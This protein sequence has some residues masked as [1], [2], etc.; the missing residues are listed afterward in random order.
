MNETFGGGG[1]GLVSGRSTRG[2]PYSCLQPREDL[3][4]HAG[5]RRGGGGAV[6]AGGDARR[7]SLRRIGDALEAASGGVELRRTL[8]PPQRT[9]ACACE[10]KKQFAAAGMCLFER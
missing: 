2:K 3:V 6:P 4:A 1:G 10:R 9:L 5:R 7:R 8:A